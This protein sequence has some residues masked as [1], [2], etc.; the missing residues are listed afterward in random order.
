MA[1]AVHAPPPPS[2]S[3]TSPPSPAMDVYVAQGRSPTLSGACFNCN[4]PGHWARNCPAKAK[5]KAKANPS[6]DPECDLP[7]VRC[8]CGRGACIVKT[9]RKQND[10]LSWKFYGCPGNAHP[11]YD[12]GCRFFKWVHDV[13]PIDV[14]YCSCRA[15]KCSLNKDS[16]GRWYFACR[17]KKG[18][19]ACE[20][21][22]MADRH[23]T[24]IMNRTR[25]NPSTDN[26]LSRPNRSESSNAEMDVE[27]TDVIDLAMEEGESVDPIID[28]GVSVPYTTSD[29]CI[30]LTETQRLISVSGGAFKQEIIYQIL[31]DHAHGWLS[32]LAFSPSQSLK[33]AAAVRCVFPSFDLFAHEFVAVVPINGGS[34]MQS[35]KQVHSLARQMSRRVSSEPS[36]MTEMQDKCF[37]RVLL[38]SYG[39]ALLDVLGSLGPA[40]HERMIKLADDTFHIWRSNLVE[41]E[42]FSHS[43]NEYIEHA[44]RLAWIDELIHGKPSSQE[45]LDLYHEEKARFDGISELHADAVAAHR[46]S[47]F[48][49]ESLSKEVERM[50]N[51]LLRMEQELAYHE[52]KTQE[53]HAHVVKISEDMEESKKTMENAHEMMD[54]VIKLEQEKESLLEDMSTALAIA[55]VQLE[56]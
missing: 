10:H 39:K 38:K 45:L 9:T 43:V 33:D 48:K 46:S 15:G 31:Y 55:A 28:N 17:I 44:S 36:S 12:E 6:P 3:S 11:P 56:E 27:V 26:S 40:D 1:G 29:I 42:P 54:E 35:Q 13:V 30:Q 22:Q 19:G 47:S 50:R 41:Y 14:P 8:P 24:E 53:D 5:A 18:F 4:Q 34:V 20:F 16:T 52:V 32:K 2:S 7:V 51:E 25:S 49:Y 21:S 37:P 23:V